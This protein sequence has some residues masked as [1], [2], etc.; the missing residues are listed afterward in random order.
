MTFTPFAVTPALLRASARTVVFI[1]FAPILACTSTA[2]SLASDAGTEKGTSE[3]TDAAQVVT[4][5]ALADAAEAGSSGVRITGNLQFGAVSC[6]STAAA[7]TLRV[8]NLGSHAVTLS[9]MLARGSASPYRVTIEG[10]TIAPSATG[11]I[12][13]TPKAIPEA[14]PVPGNYTDTLT[15]RTTEDEAP[16]L[17]PISETAE[18]AILSFD[19]QAI[20]FGEIPVSSAQSSTFHVVNGGNV[21]V[22]LELVV[23]SAPDPSFSVS[24]VAAIVA[25]SDSLTAAATFSP[26]AVGAQS[27]SVSIVPAAG[28]ALC[29][30][31][32]APLALS[33]VGENG[34]LAVSSHALT[35]GPTDCGTTAAAQ[36]V[37]LTNSGNAP[38]TWSATFANTSPSPFTLTPA[39]TGSLA[40]GASVDLSVTP[41]PIPAVS[42]V[43]AN[44]YGDALTF[45]TDVIG[46][47]P[48]LVTLSE[49]A[50]GAILAFNPTSVAFGDVPV[51]TT[52]TAAFQVTNGGNA[53]AAVIVSSS[54]AAFS[55]SPTG[56]VLVARGAQVDFT[57]AF[58]PTDGTSPSQGTFSLATNAP[59]CAPIPSPLTVSGTGTNGVVAFSPGSLS[60][61]NQSTTGFTA[62]GTTAPPQQ[63]TFSNSGNQSYTITPKLQAGAAS[64]YVLTV[65][66][67]SGVVAANGGSAT[68]TVT[69]SAIPATS[70]VPGSYGDSLSVTT[71]AAGDSAPHVISL[72]QSAYGA[73]LT[74]APATIAFPSTPANGESSIPVGITNSGNASAVLVW[75]GVSS[76]AFAFDENVSAPPGGVTTSPLAYFLPTAAQS[77]TGSAT[78]AV[79]ATTPMCQPIPD[80]GV[81]L[82]GTGTNGSIVSV[83]PAQ[84]DFNMVPC[85]TSGGSDAVTIKNDSTGT[86][87]WTATLPM[88]AAFTLGNPSS[89]T[90]APGATATLTVTS[91]VIPVSASTTTMSNGFGSQLT[92]TTNAMS[93]APHVIPIVE[94]ASGAILSFNPTNLSLPATQRGTSI[95]YAVQ[96]LGNVAASVSL[97]LDNPGPAS[98]TLNAPLAGMVSNGT[99]LQGSVTE[100]SASSPSS[101]A[102]VSVAAAA[103]T[104]LCQPLPG[105]MTIVAN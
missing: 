60:F 19:T 87:T 93:D 43:Q 21:P 94:T 11:E 103:E 89:G 42:S 53:E 90:L 5:P 36:S 76:S 51:G 63:V 35:F 83:T 37:T 73:I 77:Y 91:S 9:A 29:A 78:L 74:G 18:G 20:P 28:T 16:I 71:T 100:S 32:P 2:F 67:T 80:A 85:G 58:A 101:N 95:A 17:V 30:P 48:H 104:V 3:H 23:A 4:P 41:G 14:S 62:C 33:G 69:P 47:E 24:Q 38:L 70:A 46:D 59:L 50:R 31:L 12:H 72:S 10:A 105:P 6:G 64:P 92:V 26:I 39:T 96:N 44:F 54:A 22:K 25:S 99:P 81:S 68:I 27:S 82:S 79:T 52:A 75:N 65:S 61:G 15:I 45:N 84:V 56:S 97:T 66:P 102:T 13:V 49:T 40:P 98:L 8:E 34:G 57:G 55:A 7:R 88:G 1:S 86:I